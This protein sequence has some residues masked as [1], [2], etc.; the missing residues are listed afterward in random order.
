MDKSDRHSITIIRN[1]LILNS[2]INE[3]FNYRNFQML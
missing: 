1:N 2:K 3:N